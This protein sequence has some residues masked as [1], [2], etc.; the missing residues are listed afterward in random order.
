MCIGG[1]GQAKPGGWQDLLL[2]QLYS[3]CFLVCPSPPSF[4][5]F[6]N[7]VVMVRSGG[8]PDPFRFLERV[9]VLGYKRRAPVHVVP[10]LDSIGEYEIGESKSLYPVV[11]G[12]NAHVRKL[13]PKPNA[14]MWTQ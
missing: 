2:G 10:L 14:V 4:R 8:V 7:I 12:E 5:I 13:E 9:G 3:D 11:S 1:D 6:V